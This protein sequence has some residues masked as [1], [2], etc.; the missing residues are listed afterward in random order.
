[1]K[2]DLVIEKFCDLMIERMK[3]VG[4]DWKQPWVTSSFGGSPMNINGGHYSGM[5]DFFLLVNTMMNKFE[6]PVYATIKQ[7]NKLGGRVNKGSKSFPVV[8]W[9]AS[10]KN[11]D[12]KRVDE[13]DYEAMGRDEQKKYSYSPFL[14][15]YLVFNL[16]QTNLAEVAPKKVEKLKGQFTK[17]EIAKDTFG[18][19]E[20]AEIDDMLAMQRWYCPIKYQELSDE[21]YYKCRSFEIVVPMKTQFKVGD[22]EQEVY[23]SGQRFYDTLIHEMA[24][25]TGH[26][27]L[28]KRIGGGKY[29]QAEYAKEELVAE[30]T[31]ALCGS[32]L[33]FDACIRDD[34]AK[35]LEGWCKVLK[36]EPNF[37]VSVMSDVSKASK[38]I[39]EKIGV[40]VEVKQEA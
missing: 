9:K 15:S 39:L 27:S 17:R 11:E 30:L 38:L 3:A 18:M 23:L 35:Y 13:E 7:I 19:Y 20:N 34:N 37:I 26:E 29:S 28:L 1:M 2:T 21:A 4:T 6:L 12:G 25:S 5:N 40:G 31:A 14:K 24:H 32:V 16:D 10:Y 22:T 8:F 36:K 33:G